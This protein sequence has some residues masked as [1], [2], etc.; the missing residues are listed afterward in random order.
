MDNISL[1]PVIS[2]PFR[3]EGQR[4]VEG[5]EKRAGEH[6]V[7]TIVKNRIFPSQNEP[8]VITNRPMEAFLCTNSSLCKC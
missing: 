5:G 2:H 6:E 3:G 1:H 8:L 7:F 4:E